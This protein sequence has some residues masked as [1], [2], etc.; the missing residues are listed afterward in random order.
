MSAEILG[1]IAWAVLMAL[2]GLALP[3]GIILL[4]PAPAG[5]K[6]DWARGRL[7][8]V[9]LL[10]V[11][12]ALG[13]GFSL[14]YGA[15]HVPQLGEEARPAWQWQPLGDGSGL[16]SWAGVGVPAEPGRAA[17]F[18]GQ[19]L[20]TIVV[21]LLA[22]AP[23]HRR[24]HGPGLVGTALLVGGGLYPL[25]GHWVWGGGWLADTGQSAYLGHGVVDWG[26][27]GVLY[28]LGGLLAL[29]GLAA[30][31]GRTTPSEETG[32]TPGGAFLALVGLTGLN[33]AA[34]WG[35]FAQAGLV[36]LNTWVSAAAGG[37]VATLYMAFT[38]ARFRPAMLTRGLL[39]GAVAAAALAPLSA[40][41]SLLIVGAVAGLIACLGSYL[42]QRVWQL[43]DPAGIV[44]AFGLAGLWGVLAVGLLADGSFGQGLNGVGAERYLGVAGQG[45]TGVWPLAAGVVPDFGQLTA[46]ILG[47]GVILLWALGPGWL[48][49]R[50]ARAGHR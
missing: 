23:V 35:F 29:A 44:P 25:L 41:H 9:G 2:V 34:G 10:A 6:G 28:A 18:L 20:G 33:L 8:L 46:Q 16:L 40:P 32:P 30:T 49:F 22:L 13:C 5:A 31:E 24:L 38:T 39:A 42:V 17:L 1:H 3:A 45:V 50:L 21:T 14:Q 11:V 26:G 15:M 36:V 37:L 43:D 7:L 47:L 19:A 27:A 48:L 4:P 12:V